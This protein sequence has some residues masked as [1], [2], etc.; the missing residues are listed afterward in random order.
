[1]AKFCLD[2]LGDLDHVH[3]YLSLFASFFF[4]SSPVKPDSRGCL[5]VVGWYY[6]HYLEAMI[7]AL[8]GHFIDAIIPVE[9]SVPCD[10]ALLAG[11]LNESSA[12]DAGSRQQ[13]SAACAAA[14]G[15]AALPS[16]NS[17]AN[18]VYEYVVG[19]QQAKPVKNRRNKGRV[20]LDFE[21][22]WNAEQGIV[23]TKQHRARSASQMFILESEI[24]DTV[25]ASVKPFIG[26]LLPLM[27]CL[28]DLLRH[29]GALH[30]CLF[31]V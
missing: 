19:R 23:I 12:V 29:A 21:D 27:G 11:F 14:E 15:A 13:A 28:L 20:A 3:P 22:L 30:H 26:C 8:D 18:R 7:A 9:R 6:V 10:I 24:L 31:A 5:E 4:P 1:M 16:A 2:S 25:G 17:F